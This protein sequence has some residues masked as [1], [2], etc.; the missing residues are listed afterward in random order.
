MSARAPVTF[1]RPGRM[2]RWMMSFLGLFERFLYL[3][4]RAFA[5]LASAALE[6]RLS[7]GERMRQAVHRSMCGLCRKHKRHLLNLHAA[8]HALARAD[9]LPVDTR[10]SAERLDRIRKTLGEATGYKPPTSTP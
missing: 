6:R 5:E 2:Y 9:D 7:R 4:C 8:A 10:F 3:S 1:R